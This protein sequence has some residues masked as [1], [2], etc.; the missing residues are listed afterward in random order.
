FVILVDTLL[1]GVLEGHI[2]GAPGRPL[3][4]D[5][6]R[7][8]PVRAVVNRTH[9]RNVFEPP[10]GDLAMP[11][12]KH[13]VQGLE[14]DIRLLDPPTIPG[15]S[16]PV[17]AEQLR[18]SREWRLLLGRTHVRKDEPADLP[19]RIRGMANRVLEAALRWLGRRVETSPFPVVQPSVVEA[20]QP[21]VLHTTV[22]E[23]G[24]S[25]AAMLRHQS[26]F[27][28]PVAEQ[29]ELLAEDRQPQRIAGARER[30][31]GAA[32]QVGGHL[33]GEPVAA[34][35]FARGRARAHS[36]QQLFFSVVRHRLTPRLLVW[37]ARPP[38]YRRVHS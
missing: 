10:V 14:E 21:L 20:A 15:D 13:V 34:E 27:S 1:R 17:L 23:G 22:V 2:A 8:L 35:H 24:S 19:A 3:E 37:R 11:N 5:G 32:A 12:V 38:V 4:L 16:N 18:K 6:R 26:W 7:L 25:V 9:T 36:R 31:A 33:D 28:G 30:R 29:H